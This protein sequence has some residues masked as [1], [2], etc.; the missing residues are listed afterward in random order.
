MALD[1]FE[2]SVIKRARDGHL[3][4]V[5]YKGKPTG[6]KKEIS[7]VLQ[8]FLLKTRRPEKYGQ[9]AQAAN[10]QEQAE[11]IQKAISDMQSTLPGNNDEKKPKD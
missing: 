10:V 7:D 3:N 5:Y 11:K 1:D 4:P 2:D 9:K 8:I 6:A